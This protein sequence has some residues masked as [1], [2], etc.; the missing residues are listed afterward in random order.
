MAFDT[1]ADRKVAMVSC[2]VQPAS[3]ARSALEN[4]DVVLSLVTADQA[5]IAAET[6]APF[7]KQGAFWIDMNSVAPSTKRCASEHI[8]RQGG[9]YVDAA[10]LAPVQPSALSVPVLLSGHRQAEAAAVLADA[11]FANVRSVGDEIGKASAIKMIR[12]VMVK[13]IEALT[14]EMM[15]AARKADVADEVLSSLN[16]SASAN[17]WH[18]RAAY[19]LERMAAHGARRAAEM[20][21]VAATLLDLG[22][23][24]TMTRGTVQKQREAA[25]EGT[26]KRDVA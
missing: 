1:N 17:N 7:I 10:I 4:A 11:G 8:A 25:V 21:E 20:E 14:A 13:G 5:Q 2:E 19:N 22:V 3:D 23:D 9:N 18:E 26:Q 15:E 24:P 6:Y 16:A 12:S